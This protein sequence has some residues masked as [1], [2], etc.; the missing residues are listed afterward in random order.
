LA[1]ARA[2]AEG[3]AAA[4]SAGSARRRLAS[5]G[6]QIASQTR[7]WNFSRDRHGFGRIDRLDVDRQD[8]RAIIAE[9][10][11]ARLG[12]ASGRGKEVW[13]CARLLDPANEKIGGSPA[14]PGLRQ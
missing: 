6:T 5:A 4:G 2:S 1:L 13:A 11:A 9:R 12:Q 3:E 7:N 8:Q 14:S 10:L